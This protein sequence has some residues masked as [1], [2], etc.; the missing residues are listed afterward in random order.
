MYAGYLSA[1]LARKASI[2]SYLMGD[3][4]DM[5]DVQDERESQMQ[6]QCSGRARGL[7]V[8]L[9]APPCV[10]MI[11][12]HHHSGGG[13]MRIVQVPMVVAPSP[14][15]PMV[16]RALEQSS[17]SSDRVFAGFGR[18]VDHSEAGSVL[19]RGWIFLPVF[20]GLRVA[21]RRSDVANS[22]PQA[23]ANTIAES[24]GLYSYVLQGDTYV[25]SNLGMG[26]R[27]MLATTGELA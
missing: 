16:K 11:R 25:P 6:K 7:R 4:L 24:P 15:C 8:G 18:Y 1:P 9:Q 3:D 27:Y 22:C 21:L 10:P 2:S 20:G 17:C 23:A 5:V 19:S 26:D 12:R 14:E 13:A